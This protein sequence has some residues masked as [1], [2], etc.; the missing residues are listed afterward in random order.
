VLRLLTLLEAKVKLDVR[1]VRTV[2]ARHLLTASSG[3]ESRYLL[4]ELFTGIFGFTVFTTIASTAF[5]LSLAV[6]GLPLAVL[7]AYLDRWW[8]GL[9][10]ARATLVLGEPVPPNYTAPQ[11]GRFSRFFSILGDRQTWRDALWIVLALPAG[12]LGGAV[13]LLAWLGLPALLAAPLYVWSIPGWVHANDVWISILG[14]LL[15]VPAAVAGAWLLHPAA[16][17]HARMTALLLGPR[18]SDVLEQRVQTLAE[19][20]AGAIDAAVSELQ[21]V[22]RDLHDGAQARLVALAMDLGLAEQ[23]LAQADPETAMEHVA[24]ARGQARAA[25]AELRELVR[26][27]GPSILQDHGLD[28][29][30]TALVTGRNPP[31]ELHVELPPASA[32][33]REIA[34]YFVV[35]EALANAR[36]HAHASRIWVHAW[37]DA[38]GRLAVEVRDD[39]VGGASPE[40][41]SG[42]SGL[43]KRVAALDGT[44]TVTSPSGGPTTVRAE[45]P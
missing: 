28:A 26:G 32:G 8:C 40:R 25:M 37:E 34:A 19:T 30:L 3:R 16:M 11:G 39:G 21:R 35:A 17:A 29:A 2:L 7:V 6:I 18:R 42:L 10:R 45:I 1:L 15:A 24:S 23:R 43:V 44:L 41:G 5:G 27:I 4:T 22:E 38:D 20:R 14:P 12:A 36:K 33:P 13:A 9:A 31:V